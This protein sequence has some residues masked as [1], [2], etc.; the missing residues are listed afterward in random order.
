MRTGFGT[1]AARYADAP[2]LRHRYVDEVEA[3][4][5]RLLQRYGADFGPVLAPPVPFE[6][7]CDFL[8]LTLEPRPLA[9]TL[10]GVLGAISFSQRR[11]LIDEGCVASTRYGFT[12]CHEIGHW[13][14]HR[15]LATMP[16]LALAAEFGGGPVDL[17]CRDGERTVIE[18]EADRFAAALLMPESLVRAAAAGLDVGD[19]VVLDQFSGRFGASR[20]AMRIRLEMLRLWPVVPAGQLR[21]F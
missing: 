12:V 18:R 1:A 13:E 14:L 15:G 21:L 16:R 17:V 9:R 19:P 10:P 20:T 2:R 4:A 6:L 5:A 11:I 7:L 3:A 8:D